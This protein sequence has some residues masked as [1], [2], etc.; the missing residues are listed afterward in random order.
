MSA[1][2]AELIKNLNS[3]EKQN[4]NNTVNDANLIF[5]IELNQVEALKKAVKFFKA[6]KN[7]SKGKLKKIYAAFQKTNNLKRALDV[8]FDIKKSCN[9]S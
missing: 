8:H 9:N 7:N 3:S 5:S 1:S 6:Q 4:L 2:L